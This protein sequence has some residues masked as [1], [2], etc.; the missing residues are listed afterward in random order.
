MDQEQLD[1]SKKLSLFGAQGT[2]V[3]LHVLCP[4]CE[5][6]AV[7]LKGFYRSPWDPYTPERQQSSED[8]DLAIEFWCEAGHLFRWLFQQSKGWEFITFQ[9]QKWESITAP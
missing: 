7:H 8:C 1:A 9:T 4:V 5:C 2:D 6:F 3:G